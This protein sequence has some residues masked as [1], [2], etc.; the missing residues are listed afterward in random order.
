MELDDKTYIK[1]FN[2]TFSAKQALK[3]MLD[4]YIEKDIYCNAID[5]R[6]A[7][8]L[9]IMFQNNHDEYV[10]ASD[11]KCKHKFMIDPKPFIDPDIREYIDL[12]CTVNPNGKVYFSVPRDCD[13]LKAVIG[14]QIFAY[15]KCYSPFMMTVRN[16][17]NLLHVSS[18][19]ELLVNVDLINN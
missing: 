7:Y 13:K 19:E 10:F 12:N 17:P 5:Q 3:H 8:S 9:C 4:V 14:H 18:P 6:Y 2:Y 1:I 11:G 15:A 16:E